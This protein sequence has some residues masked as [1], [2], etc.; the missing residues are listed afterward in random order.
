[1]KNLL[2]IASTIIGI[3]ALIPIAFAALQMVPFGEFGDWL[4]QIRDVYSGGFLGRGDLSNLGHIL[5]TVGVVVGIALIY[6]F[7]SIHHKVMAA[8]K[9]VRTA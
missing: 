8:K 1:M 7:G 3:I 6:F 9:K 4:F 5:S 2:T